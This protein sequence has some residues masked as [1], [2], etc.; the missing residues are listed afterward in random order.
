MTLVKFKNGTGF[1][2]YNDL[3][4]FFPEFFHD[5]VNDA[6]LPHRVSKN[7]P[8]VNISENEKQFVVE[9]AV[10]GMKKSDFKISVDEGVLNISVEMKEEKSE[11]TRK[12]SRKEFNYSSFSRSFTL[13][14]NA[15]TENIH[16]EYTD[17][18]LNV[19]IPKAE[20]VKKNSAR[21]ITV[22]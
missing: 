10:P 20:E 2:R 6:R 5:F 3:P 18:L 9:L 7:V 17:G 16:A 19:V 21:E 1:S 14:E 22:S 12:Y 4:S 15:V 8:A 13:P 11:D